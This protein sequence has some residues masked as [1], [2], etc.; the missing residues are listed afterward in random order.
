LKPFADSEY[1]FLAKKYND[2]EELKLSGIV[3]VQYIR[4]P[5]SLKTALV[6]KVRSLAIKTP[7]TGSSGPEKTEKELLKLTK[8]PGYLDP[9]LQSITTIPPS[10]QAAATTT[11]TTATSD[12]KTSYENKAPDD[13]DGE[14]IKEE[15]KTEKR[16]KRSHGNGFWQSPESKEIAKSLTIFSE[17]AKTKQFTEK[18]GIIAQLKDEGVISEDEYKTQV[19]KLM[20]DYNLLE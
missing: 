2:D 4:S 16:V 13:D 20:K 11:T 9:D 12:Y 6:R 15:K 1:V 10:P 3:G 17:I 18:K 5:R 8:D 7:P 19:R 14:D